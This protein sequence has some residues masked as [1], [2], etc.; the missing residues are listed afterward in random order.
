V[1]FALHG[2]ACEAAV[3]CAVRWARREMCAVGASRHSVWLL[4]SVVS[5]VR[6]AL[7]WCIKCSL[8][9]ASMIFPNLIK[10]IVFS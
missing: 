5:S 8:P 7:Y 10:G 4:P 9:V 1:S 2:A 3:G 6:L